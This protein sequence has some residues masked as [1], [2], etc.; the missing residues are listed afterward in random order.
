M[1]NFGSR[2][3][4][5]TGAGF[6]RFWSIRNKLV[7]FDMNSDCCYFR[8]DGAVFFLL[9]IKAMKQNLVPLS[10]VW[11]P[12]QWW[13]QK[14]S[15]TAE[16]LRIVSKPRH[17]ISMTTSI[18]LYR[19]RW[20]LGE[21][22]VFA[23]NIPKTSFVVHKYARN[24]TENNWGM[25]VPLRNLNFEFRK[26]EEQKVYQCKFFFGSQARWSTIQYVERSSV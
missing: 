24:P 25:L 19:K 5:D 12:R 14:I 20:I 11:R 26:F 10:I 6:G 9:S 1:R 16:E 3:W 22:I 17:P 7:Y 15:C 18:N 4:I 21:G 23:V 13:R 2:L 8:Y